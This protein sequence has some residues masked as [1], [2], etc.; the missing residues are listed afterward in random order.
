[1]YFAYVAVSTVRFTR[2]NK[3]QIST[4]LELIYMYMKEQ[5]ALKPEVPKN[6]FH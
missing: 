5:M 3:A 4:V 1:M 2:P 6:P